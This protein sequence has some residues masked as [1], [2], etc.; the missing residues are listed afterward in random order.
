MRSDRVLQLKS[1]EYV[2][3]NC[4]DEAPDP[5]PPQLIKAETLAVGNVVEQYYIVC[6][7]PW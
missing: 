3:V 7:T 2:E 4:C 1:G 5:S 6:M